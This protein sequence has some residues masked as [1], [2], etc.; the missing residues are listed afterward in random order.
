M[1]ADET[2]A[3]FRLAGRTFQPALNRVVDRGGGARQLEP[4]TMEVLLCLVRAGGDVVTRE[5]LVAA[6][7]QGGFVTDDVVTRA[8][9][10]LRR[11]FEDDSAE[12]RVI[13]TIRKRGYRLLVLPEAAGE[14]PAVAPS[15][16]PAAAA[17]APV[18][19]PP[20]PARAWPL[21]VAVAA[22]VLV[23]AGG[24]WSRGRHRPPPVPTLVTVPVGVDGVEV[25]RPRL[26]PDGTRLAYA[27]QENERTRS[28]WTVLVDGG[29]PLRLTA[30]EGAADLPGAWSPDGSAL[31]YTRRG[32]A[33]CEIRIVPA[34]GGADRRVAPCGD[35]GTADLAWSP[36]G[37]TLVYAAAPADRGGGRRLRA[38][39]FATGETRDLT[40]PP[41]GWLGDDAPAFSP[42]GRQLAFVRSIAPDVDDVWVMPARGGEPRRLTD[43]HAMVI[44]VDFLGD[45]RT[46]VFSS[47]RAGLNSLWAVDV[48]GGD[49]VFLAGAG[50][51]IKHPSAARTGER[52]V[53]E[54][55]EF[56]IQLERVARDGARRTLAPGAE[57]SY[58]PQYSPDGSRLAFVSTRSGSPQIWAA[59]RDGDGA[60]QLTHAALGQVA[61]PRWSPDGRRVVF[62]GRPEGE[63]D[64]YA[65][66]ADGSGVAT[67]LTDTPG[68]EVAPSFARDGAH[69]YFAARREGLWQVHRM[70]AAGGPATPVTTGGGFAA[71]ES[72]DGTGLFYTSADA[73]GL[74]RLPLPPGSGAAVLV[75]PN[76]RPADAQA[77][78]LGALGPYVADYRP[79][80]DLESV[81]YYVEGAKE[82][83]VLADLVD[84]AWK[85]FTVAPGGEDVVYARIAR[86]V[87]RLVRL[88]RPRLR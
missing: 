80:E 77:W 70:P 31:A 71:L 49:P 27:R 2:P 54:S 28:L 5:Q 79:D 73:P 46:L 72:A 9:G 86:H 42:D 17:S 20:A 37:A 16:A 45:G 57:W 56:E 18:A 26:T 35:D 82:P 7:W 58:Q 75:L 62:V 11:L 55:W 68:D 88:D 87:C 29:A 19:P 85:G 40:A 14:R 22:L 15:P 65:V 66:A 24:F 23:A 47:S 32:T 83:P 60:I 50:P 43:D 13:E 34:L 78:E 59:A 69:L 84:L 38:L 53:F 61:S 76:L 81:R 74:R 30:E 25:R 44:G 39:T 64:L 36:D 51:K 4:K 21:G 10:Q 67:R 48:R 41:A 63:A 1:A 6:V 8:I 33:G 52:V 12:P 3:E